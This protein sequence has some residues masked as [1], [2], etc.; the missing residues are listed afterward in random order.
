MKYLTTLILALA[1]TACATPPLLSGGG[2]A[3]RTG[4]ADSDSRGIDATLANTSV[5]SAESTRLGYN[6][7]ESGSQQAPNL[8]LNLQP[9]EGATVSAAY[10]ALQTIQLTIVNTQGNSQR[11]STL[12][13]DQ[14]DKVSDVVEKT[15][16][17][18]ERATG[19]A[20]GEPTEEA[21]GE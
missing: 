13:P 19:K 9:G 6:R 15:G 12:G 2:A 8:V 5:G 18:L 4:D 20:T 7:N 17:A 14:L 10:P 11:D 1:L 16:E 21:A 3:G